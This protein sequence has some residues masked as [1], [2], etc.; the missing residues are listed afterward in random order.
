[1][2]AAVWRA[3]TSR[4]PDLADSAASPDPGLGPGAEVDL[5]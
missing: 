1:V 5:R 4:L 3:V 2:A